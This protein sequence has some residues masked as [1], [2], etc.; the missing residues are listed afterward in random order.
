MKIRL[1]IRGTAD[2]VVKFEDKVDLPE[3]ELDALLPEL[4]TKHATA[5]AEHN[6]DMIEIEF[7]D[8]VNPLARFFRIGVN[9]NSMVNPIEI[10]LTVMGKPN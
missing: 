9:P 4:A 10:D 8:E 1:A 2:G 7:L 3:E 6:L 5:M